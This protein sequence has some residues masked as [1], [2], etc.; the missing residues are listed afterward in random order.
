MGISAEKAADGGSVR[1]V[2]Y[3][4]TAQMTSMLG[5]CASMLVLVDALMLVGAF[6]TSSNAP[7]VLL[8]VVFNV[9]LISQLWLL[10]WRLAGRVEIA[11]ETIEWRF[12]SGTRRAYL[13][14]VVRVRGSRVLLGHEV[15]EID[16]QQSIIVMS[17]PGFVEFAA[18]LQQYRPE[19]PVAISWTSRLSAF[20]L[21]RSNT[22]VR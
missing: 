14:E 18:W 13:G 10:T 17:R 8:V 16:G 6:S 4:P 9:I 22:T 7:S 11:V 15:I 20:A 1:S 3:A 5:F 21:L 2:V 19:L 12:L